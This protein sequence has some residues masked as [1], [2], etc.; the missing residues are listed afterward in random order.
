MVFFDEVDAIAG[1][2]DK[3]STGQQRLLAQ[4]LTEID[5]IHNGAAATHDGRY[6]DDDDDDDDDEDGTSRHHHGGKSAD[7][8]L[9]V[10]ATNR[11]D[12]LD[13]ALVRPGR[14]DQMIYVG[15]P[16]PDA[17]GEIL[18]LNLEGVSLGDDVDVG[19]IVGLTEG[20]SGAEVVEVVREACGNRMER[21]KVE[22]GGGE[23]G[24]GKLERGGLVKAAREG[25]RLITKEMRE[26]YEGFR[27]GK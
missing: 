27:G 1:E 25:R 3:G 26:F 17:R 6:D 2:R 13:P 23:S 12:L 14:V 21:W 8:V 11:P 16:D 5:G 7:G 10:C 4:M 22:G 20:C 19:E 24:G 15:P 9:V 18:R